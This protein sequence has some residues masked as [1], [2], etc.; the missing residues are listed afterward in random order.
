[1]TTLT[2]AP[3]NQPCDDDPREW[4]PDG[5]TTWRCRVCDRVFLIGGG[6]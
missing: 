6:K 4:V 3:P 5:D 1:M 2:I